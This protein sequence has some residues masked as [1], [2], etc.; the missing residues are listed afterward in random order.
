LYPKTIWHT[1]L[2]LQYPLALPL[3]QLSSLA[4][5]EGFPVI[6]TGEGADELMGGYDCFRAQRMRRAFDRPLLRTLRPFVYHQLYKWM[7]TPKG[8]V[9]HYLRCQERPIRDVTREFSGAFPA[10]YD[11]WQ[12]L[13]VERSQLLSP[14][15]RVPRRTTSAPSEFAEL[16]RDDITELDA[17][18]AE[19]AIELETRLPAWI[20]LIGDRAGMANSVEMRVP[21]L[22]HEVVEFLASLEPRL[23]MSGFKEKAVL[24]GAMKGL[25]PE[26]IRRRPKRPFYTPLKQW[27]FQPGASDY[28]EAELNERALRDAGLFAPEVVKKL[29]QDL[30][31]VP[32]DHLMRFQL[33]WLLVQ[34]L[35]TQLLHRLFVADFDPPGGPLATWRGA[36]T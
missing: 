17:L 20:L 21:F 1:E 32:D 25:L 14:D 34:V 5:T 31:L 18:D 33:E 27:F 3:M 23:K 22:D 6:L 28:V 4:K 12:A 7:G 13:D 30:D 16:V 8:A 15:G 11:V 10:W 19:L 2:P 24:R 35:G 36:S 29:R 9:E 26:E